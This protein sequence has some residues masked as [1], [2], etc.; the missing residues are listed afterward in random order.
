MQP[1]V[2]IYIYIF[3]YL[4]SEDFLGDVEFF[5]RARGRGGGHDLPDEVRRGS[6]FSSLKAEEFP[7]CF[8]PIGY[9]SIYKGTIGA[10]VLK[11]KC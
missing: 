9:A 10:F 6:G 1:G 11:Q 8:N 4:L 2:H 3:I 5:E 7:P